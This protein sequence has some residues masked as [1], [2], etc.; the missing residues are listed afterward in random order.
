MSFDNFDFSTLNQQVSEF[1]SSKDAGSTHSET[2]AA[3][4]PSE[5]IPAQ[6]PPSAP[7][8]PAKEPVYEVD[9]GDGKGVQ[10]LTAKEIR[11]GHLRHADYT[12][13]TQELAAQRKQFET[14]QTQMKELQEERD[15]LYQIMQNPQALMYLAMQQGG[16][17]PQQQQFD[18]NAPMTLGQARDLAT[19]QYEAVNAEIEKLK[20]DFEKSL[21][22]KVQKTKQELE[23]EREQARYAGMIDDT[24]AHIHKEHPVLTAVPEFEDVVRYRVFTGGPYNNPQEM[25]DAFKRVSGEVAK[26]VTDKVAELNKPAVEAKNKILS[27]GIEPPGGTGIQP[28]PT[29]S[30]RDKRT[31]NM[32]WKGLS[33][34][35]V[36]YLEQF[37]KD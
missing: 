24:F 6:A 1:L 9:F 36:S 32:D 10:K 22:E 29:Q 14:S 31:G 15:K 13:K 17:M 3:P 7:P 12:K 30:F 27:G 35:A 5:S 23:D 33:K 26:M 37:R 16:L 20:Q 11:D 19:T 8:E 18:P 2:P 21:Q 4:A 34:G 28:A 25:L